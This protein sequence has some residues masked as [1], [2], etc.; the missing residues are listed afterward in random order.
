MD[1]IK[2]V[3]KLKNSFIVNPVNYVT[4]SDLQV[5]LAQIIKQELTKTKQSKIIIS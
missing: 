5:E 1:Y 2:I 4:E 3:E